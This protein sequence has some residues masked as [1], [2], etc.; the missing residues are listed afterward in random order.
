VV[1]AQAQDALISHHELTAIGVLQ[2][3]K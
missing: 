3:V 2:N 1:I